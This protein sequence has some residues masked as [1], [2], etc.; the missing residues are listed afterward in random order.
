MPVE[1]S[2]ID[3][4]PPTPQCYQSP[5]RLRSSLTCAQYSRPIKLGAFH[6]PH[7]SDLMP[8]GSISY[9]NPVRDRISWSPSRKMRRLTLGART[10][11]PGVPRSSGY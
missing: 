8:S 7:G 4:K 1:C 11:P 3:K 9:E 2:P 10:L 5:L 6:K